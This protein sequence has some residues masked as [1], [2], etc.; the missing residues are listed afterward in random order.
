MGIDP[1]LRKLVRLEVI[2]P[3]PDN[4]DSA[5]SELL[6][7][8]DIGFA[9]LQLLAGSFN[10][11][12]AHVKFHETGEELKARSGAWMF[13]NTLWWIEVCCNEDGTELTL[14]DLPLE[15][16]LSRVARLAERPTLPDRQV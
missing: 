16:H 8:G 15:W 5:D 14:F 2:I 9:C 10:A 6:W 4:W 1:T 12:E 11:F 13:P 7:E 3:T